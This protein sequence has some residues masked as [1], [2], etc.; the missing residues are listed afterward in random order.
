MKIIKASYTNKIYEH[1][2]LTIN[3]FSNPWTYIYLWIFFYLHIQ[4]WNPWTYYKPMN[5]FSI[6]FTLFEPMNIVSNLSEYFS[7][8]KNIFLS[9]NILF[10]KSCKLVLYPWAFFNLWTSV[11]FFFK[12]CEYL[13]IFWTFAWRSC[14]VTNVRVWFWSP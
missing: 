8:N 4:L 7:K 1:G 14:K 11:Q 9:E 3:I 12:I 10:R 2:F 13:Y 5:T 6:Q